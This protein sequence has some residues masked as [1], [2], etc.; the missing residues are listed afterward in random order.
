VEELDELALTA[1]PLLEEANDNRGLV[2]AWN[3]ISEASHHRGRWEERCRSLQR[4]LDHGRLAGE[5]PTNSME[6]GAA[7]VL[8]PEPADELLRSLDQLLPESPHP[9]RLLVRARLLAMLDRPAEAWPLALQANERLRELTGDDGGEQHLA[10][11]ATLSGDNDAAASYLRIRCDWLEANHRLNNLSTYAPMLGRSL[12]ALGR[13]DEAEPLARQGRTL[14]HE[15]DLTTQTLWRQVRARVLAHRGEHSEAEQL[16]REAV[17]I[18]NRTD[19]LNFQ[20]DA[21]CDLAEV[22]TAGGRSDEATAALTQALD[23]YERKR[24]LAM[25]RRVRVRLGELQPA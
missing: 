4:A 5:R 10:E 25:A 11:I 23:R 12:C 19:G 13:H 21:L 20:G 22:L 1:L 14:G 6:L 24:N 3:A 17:A 15:Q 2:H 16:A 7:L 18:I 8:G 9:G